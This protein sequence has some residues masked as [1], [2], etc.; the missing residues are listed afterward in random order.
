MM[1]DSYCAVPAGFHE[2]IQN[3][4]DASFAEGVVPTLRIE[5]TDDGLTLYTNELGFSTKNIE[6]ICSM[7]VPHKEKPA[8][9]EK[10]TW[11]M[12]LMGGV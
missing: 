4:D 9:G 7:A 6:A 1:H 12:Q 2:L 3:A 10:G 5:A 11:A 8:T